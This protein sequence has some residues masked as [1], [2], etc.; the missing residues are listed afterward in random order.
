MGSDN[1]RS[2]PGTPPMWLAQQPD[3]GVE[4][5]SF[6]VAATGARL[7]GSSTGVPSRCFQAIEAHSSGVN[8]V[9]FERGGVLLATAGDD[10][11]VKVWDPG[12]GRQRA[13][14]KVRAVFFLKIGVGIGSY[15]SGWAGGDGLVVC[16]CAFMSSNFVRAPF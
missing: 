1:E 7:S 9:V 4:E 8:D 10:S 5:A 3:G 13:V 12:S 11:Y 15:G 16:V 14:L 2:E 6:A